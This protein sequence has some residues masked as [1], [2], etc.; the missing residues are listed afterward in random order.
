MKTQTLAKV[1]NNLSRHPH[2]DV[3]FLCILINLLLFVRT[4]Q[5]TPL[6]KKFQ[7]S[8]PSDYVA[9]VMLPTSEYF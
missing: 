7:L 5:N 9:A 6:I 2:H 4:H 1:A 3:K 8:L